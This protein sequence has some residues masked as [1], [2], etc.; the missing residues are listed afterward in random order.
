MKTVLDSTPVPGVRL[1]Y[2][3]AVCLT[4]VSGTFCVVCCTILGITYHGLYSSYS[5]MTA[6]EITAIPTNTPSYR[7]PAADSFNR[8][9]NDHPDLL[10]LRHALSQN[11]QD[12]TLKAQI[13][14]LDHKLRID[15]FQRRTIIQRIAVLLFASAILLFIALRTI[16]V[17]KRQIPDPND[18]NR[19]S[20]K[21]DSW[22]FAVVISWLMLFV[23]F[24]LGLLLVPPSSMEQMFLA[25]LTA[26]A[27][28]INSRQ[29]DTPVINPV[30]NAVLAETIKLTEE[31][32]V[33]HWISFRNFDGNGIGFSDN[34]PIHWN[35]RTGENILWNAEVPLPGK[36]SPVLWTDD[37]GGGKLFVTGADEKAQKI[38][39]YNA[40]N[41]ELL[42]EADVTKQVEGVLKVSEDTGY[43]A[44]TTVV[45]GRHVYAMFANGELV[46]VD[47][48][49]KLVWRKSF[50]IPDNMYGFASSPAL[51]FDRLIVQFDNGDGEDGTS[52]LFAFDLNTGDVLWETNRNMPNSWSSPMV[53][54][55]GDSYQIITCGNPFVI[56]YKPEDGKEIW[57]CKCLG[58]DIGPSPVALG[59]IVLVTN[60]MPRTSAIDATGSGDITTTHIVWQGANALPDTVSPMATEDYFLT[61]DSGGY[62]TGYDPKRIDPERKRANFWELELG[63]GMANIYSSPLRVGNYVYVF[64]KTEKDP[65]AFV[66]DLSKV[67]VD[68][69]GMLTEESAV[70]MVIAENPMADPCE[71]SPAILNNRLYIRG[72]N[73]IYCITALADKMSV[74]PVKTGI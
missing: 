26:D 72:T 57:R 19:K 36:S 64:D 17:L 66:I 43:A 69:N 44:P 7:K 45:D 24:Y 49:G 74:I 60:Q 10:T 15:Y 11:R 5:T 61:L 14:E 35:S 50:G 31:I 25:K 27:T 29:A 3:L 63:D 42:W 73:T 20:E 40:E 28:I 2:R 21:N 39:C 23:G 32:L 62:L 30:A 6:A 71:T 52:K 33:K 51:C 59:N 22:H 47:F 58:G 16:G 48:T 70:E 4:A 9:P 37:S 65:K 38:F 53:K 8:L 54:K 13:R 67:V 12:E 55:I 56:A 68:D 34:P 46:A 1:L 18:I 41:G